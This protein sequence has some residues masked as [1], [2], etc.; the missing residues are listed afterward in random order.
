M[1][2]PF[3]DHLILEIDSRFDKYGKMIQRMISPVVAERDDVTINA[4]VEM[5]KDDL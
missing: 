4:A 2:I 3:L 5:Y 1:C